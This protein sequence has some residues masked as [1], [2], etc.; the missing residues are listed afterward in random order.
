[1]KARP[2][3]HVLSSAS[4]SMQAQYLS[5]LEETSEEVARVEESSLPVQVRVVTLQLVRAGEVVH[6]VFLSQAGGRQEEELDTRKRRID[7][8]LMDKSVFLVARPTI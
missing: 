2:L 8:D 4:P 1:M 5:Q 3:P 7:Q 6:V